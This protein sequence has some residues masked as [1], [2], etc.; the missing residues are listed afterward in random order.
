MDLSCAI[1]TE[2]NEITGITYE[3]WHYRYVGRENAEQIYREGFCLE[4]YLEY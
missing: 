3:P 4:E 2:K 1:L